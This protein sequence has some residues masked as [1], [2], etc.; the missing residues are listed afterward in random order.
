MIATD[1]E[2]TAK[3]EA[4]HYHINKDSEQPYLFGSAAP[5]LHL[6]V[7]RGLSV[8]SAGR[9][10]Y[11]RQTIFLDGVYSD[12]PFIDNETRQY[13]LVHHAGC[14]R[15][16]TLATC[17][18]AAVFVLEGLPLDEGVWNLF[19]NEPDLDAVLASWI[20]INHHTLLRDDASILRNVMPFIRVEGHDRRYT[21]SKKVF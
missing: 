7:E 11:P 5:N 2:S 13:S 4:E 18:Q 21:V 9:K 8:N 6:R 17:E 19:I 3:A 20:L 16:F 15:M 12:A 10:Y 14:I 1:S